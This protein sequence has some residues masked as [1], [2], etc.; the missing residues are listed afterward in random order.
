ML[1]KLRNWLSPE[2]RA[3]RAVDTEL[4]ALHAELRALKAQRVCGRLLDERE[5][6][7]NRR[8]AELKR[9]RFIFNEGNKGTDAIHKPE[10]RVPAGANFIFSS[11]RIDA[12]PNLGNN[13][14]YM[15]VGGGVGKIYPLP[16]GRVEEDDACLMADWLRSIHQVP[17]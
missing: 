6:T 10:R 1:Q 8:V 13:R 5:A 7:I 3:A 11:G 17:K 9:P 15:V 12:I 14:R 2:A 4:A 16:A